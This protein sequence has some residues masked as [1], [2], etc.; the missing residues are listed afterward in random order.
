MSLADCDV[1]RDMTARCRR[2]RDRVCVF[3]LKL[4]AMNEGGVFKE[5]PDVK[6]SLSELGESE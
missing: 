4:I 1:L 6:W 5:I 3:D 2:C